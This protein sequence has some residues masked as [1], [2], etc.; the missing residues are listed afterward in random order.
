M[1]EA[2]SDQE[3]AAARHEVELKAAQATVA[4]ILWDNTLLG[5]ENETLRND[6]TVLRNANR[7]L[8]NELVHTRSQVSCFD[9]A[10]GTAPCLLICSL[11][12]VAVTLLHGE[13][14]SRPALKGMP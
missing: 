1:A 9:H 11:L 6:N 7:T 8:G 10:C 14:S 12:H 2:L 5:N 13:V 3:Q 4:C